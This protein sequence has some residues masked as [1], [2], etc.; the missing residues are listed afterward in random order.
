MSNK[1]KD[2]F[3]LTKLRLEK[4]SPPFLLTSTFTREKPRSIYDLFCEA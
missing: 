1:T 2:N 3:K 4:A